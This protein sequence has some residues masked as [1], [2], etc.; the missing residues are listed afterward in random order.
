MSS[1]CT[2]SIIIIGHQED[3]D[4]FLEK[5]LRFSS[6]FPSPT[7]TNI[8]A[9]RGWALATWGTCMD[10]S[11]QFTGST[12]DTRTSL[13]FKSDNFVNFH[14]WTPDAPPNLFLENLLKQY[15]RCW[16]KNSWSDESGKA[17]IW[18]AYMRHGFLVKQDMAW[19]EPEPVVGEDGTIAMP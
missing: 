18:I 19:N 12:L 15:P 10:N 11:I 9:T 17:G 16:I 14:V 6:F 1:D 2:S 5:N 3:L 4:L 7:P 13:V 8:L